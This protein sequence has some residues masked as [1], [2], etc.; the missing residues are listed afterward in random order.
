MTRAILPGVE[1]RDLERY[2]DD[3]GWLVEFLRRPHVEDVAGAFGQMYMTVAYPGKT[4]GGHW[5]RLKTEWF[6][7]VQGRCRARLR[8]VESGQSTE[9]ILQAERPCVMK[10]EPGVAHLFENAGE[11][12]MALLIYSDK[13]FDPE[14]PDS[15]PWDFAEDEG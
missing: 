14:A 2:E 9:V 15:E 6:C 1:L 11:G 12:E 7:V 10:V 4:K 3:R 8:C 13:L 5:H